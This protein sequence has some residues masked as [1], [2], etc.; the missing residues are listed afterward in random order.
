MDLSDIRVLD[1]T[2]FFPGPY[3]TQILRDYGAEVIKIERPERGD[4][5]RQLVDA[6]DDELSDLFHAVNRGKK[7]ITLDLTTPPGQQAFYELAKTADVV[8]EQFRPGVVDRLDIDYDTLTEYNSN[9]VYCSLTGYGQT[10]QYH[11]QPGH[12]LTYL[13]RS[14]FLSMNRKHSNARPT[15]PA[16]PIADAAGSAHAVIGILTALLSR[17][18]SNSSGTYLDV[19]MTDALIS[20]SQ[21]I[22]QPALTGSAVHPGETTLTGK[23]PCYNI[24]ETKDSRFIAI[25][26]LKKKF[27]V[28]LCE[29]LNRT[30]LIDYH[31]SPTAEIREAVRSELADEINSYTLSTWKDEFSRTNIPFAPVNTIE[32]ALNEDYLQNRGLIRNNSKTPP[33]IGIPV[34]DVASSSESKMIPDLGEHTKEVLKEIDISD[35]TRSKILSE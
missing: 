14:G 13:A 11:D 32:E 22:T 3:A 5:A 23:Y 8:I 4:P 19:S 21:M 30:D 35:A 9:I 20:F 12:D 31:R 18:L 1:L 24:Y 10:G 28:G 17:E 34:S 2:Q 6:A 15:M 7:S 29:T 26:A 16:I 27:W 33:R 25:A